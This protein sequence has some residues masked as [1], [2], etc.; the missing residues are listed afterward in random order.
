[1]K[2]FILYFTMLQIFLEIYQYLKKK[3]QCM[4]LIHLCACNFGQCNK[5]WLIISV[6]KPKGPEVQAPSVERPKTAS[7]SILTRASNLNK[8]RVKVKLPNFVYI[9]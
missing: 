6:N 1:M 3:L 4:P 8:D 7:K 5:Y 2:K 9:L